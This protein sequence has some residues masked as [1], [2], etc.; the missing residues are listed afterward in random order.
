MVGQS[1]TCFAAQTPIPTTT[2]SP[3]SGTR[4]A[5]MTEATTMKQTKNSTDPA[6]FP[7]ERMV[8]IVA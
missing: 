8:R 4:F 2:A 1:T 3:A 7:S 6:N 5:V